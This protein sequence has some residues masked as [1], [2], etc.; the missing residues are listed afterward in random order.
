[1][2]LFWELKPEE[3]TFFVTEILNGLFFLWYCTWDCTGIQI[4][5]VSQGKTHSLWSA[6][7]CH[8]IKGFFILFCLLTNSEDSKLALQSNIQSLSLIFFKY[9]TQR[10]FG[11]RKVKHWKFFCK[12]FC[13]QHTWKPCLPLHHVVSSLGGMSITD[14]MS[15]TC[16]EQHKEERQEDKTYVWW[17]LYVM[18]MQST[19]DCATWRD[20]IVR[21][22]SLFWCFM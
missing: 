12:V 8:T 18:P 11:W 10:R 20:Y 9:K 14:T 15:P 5:L 7:M 3:L 13:K 22:Q 1:M 17:S 16:R 19:G 21:L 4:S 2:T 6:L